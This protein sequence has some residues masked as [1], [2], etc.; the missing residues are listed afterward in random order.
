M[1]C[2]H[3][4]CC[5]QIVLLV[6]GNILFVLT[7]GAELDNTG[8]G[9]LKMGGLELQLISQIEDVPLRVSGSTRQFDYFDD[10]C[11][12]VIF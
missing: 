7:G 3:H 11:S 2:S 1:R 6:Y 4:I 5:H 10:E 12:H 9:L 8:S